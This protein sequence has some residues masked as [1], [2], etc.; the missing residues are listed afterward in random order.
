MSGQMGDPQEPLL[1]RLAARLAAPVDAASRSRARLHL[2]D[3][4]GC[5]AAAAPDPLAGALASLAPLSAQSGTAPVLARGHATPIQALLIHGALGSALELDDLD[6]EALLHPSAA[7]VPAAL[8]ACRPETPGEELLDAVV[9]GTEAMVRIGRALGPGHYRFWH[10]SST[11]G[12][13]GAAAATASLLRLD[14][15]ATAHALA[16]AGSRTGGLWQ[17][18]HEPVPTKRLHFALAALEGF[19]AAELAAAGIPGPLRLLEGEQGLFAATAPAARPEAVLAPAGSW[20]IHELSFKPYPACRH[21]HPAIDALAALLPLAPAEIAGIEVACYAAAVAFC[22]R[23]EPASPEEARFSLQHAL[24]ARILLGEPEPAHYRGAALAD[25]ALAA[26][27][28][29]IRLREDEELSRA[30]PRRFGARVRITLADGRE[31]AAEARDA[32]GDPERP[33]A[34]AELI[35]KARRLFAEG[36]LSAAGAEGLI[37]A[38][39][40][41]DGRP[42]APLLAAIAEA[43]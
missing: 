26:L 14:A 8:A 5:A 1:S 13:F 40:T 35:A 31:L 17:L 15:A 36:G 42:A 22:D 2:L 21:V 7:V 38:A 4:L 43:R 6:R 16:T 23:P 41:L 33:L 12:A 28:R 20:L 27:R 18:R 32:R 24:A 10:P 30:F 19:L 3:W 34:E 9:R 11:C 25:P 37:A 29:R 39:L